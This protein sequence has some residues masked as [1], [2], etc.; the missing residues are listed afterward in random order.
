[1]NVNQSSQGVYTIDVGG[2][3]T[4]VAVATPIAFGFQPSVTLGMDYGN[5]LDRFSSKTFGTQTID[6][7]AKLYTDNRVTAENFRL[8]LSHATAASACPIASVIIGALPQGPTA[9][10]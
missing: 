10:Y 2:T 6:G 1:M 8:V 9:R 3:N 5:G 4:N 7:A